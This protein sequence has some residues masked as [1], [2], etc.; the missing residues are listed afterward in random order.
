RT[1]L[2][3]ALPLPMKRAPIVYLNRSSRREEALTSFAASR[4]SLLTSAATRFMERIVVFVLS[5][6]MLLLFMSHLGQAAPL[7]AGAAAVDI[8]PTN[9]PIRTAGNLTLTVV[10]NIH[11]ALHARALVLDDGTTTLAIATVDSCMVAREDLEAA[12]LLARQA[13]G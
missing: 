6:A 9:L 4:M 2:D 12:K 8:T 1:G 7:R 11:D 3:G 13:T 10:S 5:A